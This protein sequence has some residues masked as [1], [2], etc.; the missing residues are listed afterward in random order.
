MIIEV[1]G[2]IFKGSNYAAFT[3][4]SLLNKDQFFKEKFAP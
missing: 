4:V 2:N 1:N 3:I